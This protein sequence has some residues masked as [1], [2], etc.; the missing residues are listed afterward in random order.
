MGAARPAPKE[1]TSMGNKEQHPKKEV[2]KPKKDKK[3]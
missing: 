1:H 3:K 2:K